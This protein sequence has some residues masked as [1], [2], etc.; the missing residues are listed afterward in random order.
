MNEQLK[1]SMHDQIDN[2]QS[3]IYDVLKLNYKKNRDHKDDHAT[4]TEHWDFAKFSEN[5]ETLTRQN[6]LLNKD[7]KWTQTKLERALTKEAEKDDRISQQQERIDKLR[8]QEVEYRHQLQEKEARIREMR[9]LIQKKE[10]EIAELELQVKNL[11]S[12]VTDKEQEYHKMESAL[13]ARLQ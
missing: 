3:K 9:I 10:M 12:K 6:A 5:I 1:S 2:L 7:L 13:K 11:E 4:Q 8:E